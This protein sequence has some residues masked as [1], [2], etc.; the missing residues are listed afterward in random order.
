MAVGF[1]F[2]IMFYR[3]GSLIACI[4]THSLVNAFSVFQNT[5]AITPLIEIMMSIAIIV[6]AIVYS[7]IL[8]KT[9]KTT[10]IQS[11]DTNKKA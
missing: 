11:T 10:Q 2:V 4:L 9:L 3:G 6:I 5:Q 1:L 7:I 8:L